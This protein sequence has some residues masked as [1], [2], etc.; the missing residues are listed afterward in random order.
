VQFV[1]R[2]PDEGNTGRAAR[3]S[4]QG[5]DCPDIE[6]LLDSLP[7]REREVMLLRHGFGGNRGMSLAEVADELHIS[8]TRVRQLE[9]RAIARLRE[10]AELIAR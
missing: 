6:S 8:K 1:D 9:Q 4:R 5:K 2:Y 3:E 10:S 7:T